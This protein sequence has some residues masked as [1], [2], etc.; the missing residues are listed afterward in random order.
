MMVSL[1][2]KSKLQQLREYIKSLESDNKIM[3]ESLN[4][5]TDFGFKNSGK[6]YS[7]ATMAKTT[8]DRLKEES[9]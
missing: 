7:C 1:F 8:L 9:K 2:K 3:K 5:I 4:N 6:G